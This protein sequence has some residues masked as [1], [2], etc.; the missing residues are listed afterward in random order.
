MSKRPVLPEGFDFSE[1][2]AMFPSVHKPIRLSLKSVL[3]S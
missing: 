2:D 3:G 1:S